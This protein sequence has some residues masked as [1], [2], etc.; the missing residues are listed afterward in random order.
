M[1]WTPKRQHQVGGL[2]NLEMRNFWRNP[3]ENRK[4]FWISVE[5]PV[6][7]FKGIPAGFS[8]TF[9]EILDRSAFWTTSVLFA[10]VLR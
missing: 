9:T 6:Q 1:I 10:T 7:C 3:S 2:G 4:A 5:D 8:K